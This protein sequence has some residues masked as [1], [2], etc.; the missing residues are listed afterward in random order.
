MDFSKRQ[1]Q[2][3]D[4]LRPKP[5]HH[6]Q[7]ETELIAVPNLE[8]KDIS[9]ERQQILRDSFVQEGSNLIPLIVR[10]TEAYA[11]EEY[12]VIYGADWCLV[13]KELDIER[14][15]VWVF[16]LDDEQA[17]VTQ[18]EMELLLG[19]LET[20][21]PTPDVIKQMSTLFQRHENSLEK[22]I[23]QQISEAIEQQLP[24]LLKQQLGGLETPSPTPDVIKQMSTLVQGLEQLLEKI[25]QHSETM[26]RAIADLKQ[27]T[28]SRRRTATSIKNP[29]EGMTIHQLRK[30]LEDRQLEYS[31]RLREPGLMKLLIKADQQASH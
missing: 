24:K 15:W 20:P 1:K 23:S 6:G 31:S 2:I 13:A 7:L 9:P 26:N 12:E 25:S 21:S 19:G 16:D 14:L 4:R 10:R 28:S 11:D 30:L 27:A 8:L 18:S 22:K 3:L 29:Y 5:L 17:A